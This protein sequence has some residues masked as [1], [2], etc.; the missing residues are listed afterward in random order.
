MHARAIESGSADSGAVRRSGVRAPAPDRAAPSSRSGAGA[1]A[2]DPDRGPG[3]GI[4][5]RGLTYKPV[6]IELAHVL[7]SIPGNGHEA[8]EDELG[9]QIDTEDEHERRGDPWQVNDKQRT[10]RCRAR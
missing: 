4:T 7:H 1:C 6:A 5:A 3:H 10:S 9:V 8:I 2:G